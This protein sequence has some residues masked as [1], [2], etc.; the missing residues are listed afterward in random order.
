MS[1]ANIAGGIPVGAALVSIVFGF[2]DAVGNYGQATNRMPGE[3]AYMFPYVATI[4]LLVVMN[5]YRIAR[6]KRKRRH[7]LEE[8]ELMEASDGHE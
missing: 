2:S 1:A 7:R 4:V 8:A 5:L 3:F 6:E